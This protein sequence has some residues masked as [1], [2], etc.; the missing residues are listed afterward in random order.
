MKNSFTELIFVLDCS[1]SM[2]GLESDVIGSFNAII[3]RQKAS[4]NQTFVTTVLCSKDCRLLHDHIPL[5]S[6]RPITS[7]EYY[8]QGCSA[9]LDGMG[10]AICKIRQMYAMVSEENQPQ[11]VLFVMITD[12]F[13][14]SSVIFSADEILHMVQTQKEKQH[15]EFVFLGADLETISMASKLEIPRSRT[16]EALPVT[17]FSKKSF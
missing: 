16:E 7:Q 17:Y 13:E 9:F 8:V 2:F 10:T 1:G 15:W 6:I 12:G 4:S 5:H 14:N 3:A 11:Q